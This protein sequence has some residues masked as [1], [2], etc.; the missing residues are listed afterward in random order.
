MGTPEFCRNQTA[1]LSRRAVHLATSEVVPHK[2]KTTDDPTAGIR[3]DFPALSQSV[4]VY[5]NVLPGYLLAFT[6]TDSKPFS[7]L[8]KRGVSPACKPLRPIT[9]HK[10]CPLD[11]WAS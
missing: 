10:Y 11:R 2:H 6:C 3:F 8:V 7:N 4:V 1:K 9:R 5:H